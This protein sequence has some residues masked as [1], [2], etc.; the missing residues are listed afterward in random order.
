MYEHSFKDGETIY[1]ATRDFYR[2]F[3]F[4]QFRY[5]D[6]LCNEARWQETLLEFVRLQFRNVW[7]GS[8]VRSGSMRLSAIHHAFNGVYGQPLFS[9]QLDVFFAERPAFNIL[10][11][12]APNPA[13]SRTQW[14]GTLSWRGFDSETHLKKDVHT[15]VVIY[16]KED[17]AHL[18]YASLQA[19]ICIRA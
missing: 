10:V 19:P 8:G 2:S 18:M 15:R 3:Q 5:E 16:C 13:A 6:A 4:Y 17:F 1:F 12:R 11:T 9:E 7:W 14:H